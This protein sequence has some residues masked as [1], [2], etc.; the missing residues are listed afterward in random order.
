MMSIIKA[1][2]VGQKD[3]LNLVLGSA[4]CNIRALHQ[5]NLGCLQTKDH[6]L[7]LVGGAQER[8]AKFS[9]VQQHRPI[10][11]QIGCAKKIS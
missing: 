11:H 10:N 7:I 6:Q 5:L 9:Q 2:W 3:Q 8:S 1:N 4:R